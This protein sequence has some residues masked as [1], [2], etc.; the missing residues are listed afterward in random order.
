[1]NNGIEWAVTYFLMLLALFMVGGGRY[2]SLDYWIR[3]RF[4]RD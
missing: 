1:M 4:M 2:F 3:R